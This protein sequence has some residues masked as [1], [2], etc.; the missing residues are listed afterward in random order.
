MG[1]RI[2]IDPLTRLEGQGKISIFL[3]D[4]GE[5]ERAYFQS[6]DLRGFEKFCEGRAAEELPVLTQ[7]ICGV[8]PTAHH[9]A[10]S[11]ALDDL[12]Q[13][14]PPP[15]ARKIR[16]LI[17]N[18]FI[19]EDHLL[20]FYFLGGCDLLLGEET[21]VAER[22]FL[23]VMKRVG[24]SLG[25]KVIQVR[26]EVR[27][28][29]T[30]LSGGPLYPVVGLPGGVSKSLDQ[31]DRAE[32]IRVAP[33]AL[34]LARESLTLFHQTLENKKIWAK[35]LDPIFIQSTYYLGLVDQDQRVN[36]YDGRLRVVDPGGEELACFQPGDYSRHLGERTE[37]WTY[38]RIPYLK[39]IGWKGWFEGKANGIYRAGPLGRLNASRGMATP[40][41]QAEYARMISRFGA[42]PV[43]HTLAYHWARLI[44]TLYAAERMQELA[45]DPEL[46]NPEVR[47]IP[48]A[49]PR[50]G[51]GVCEASRGTLIH[52]YRTDERG[53]V[54]EM[55]LLVATQ[56]SM[57]ALCLA[58]EKAAKGL[59]HK[60]RASEDLLNQIEM[61][62]RA[63][64]PCLACATHCLPGQSPLAVTFYT[65]PSPPGRAPAKH[66]NPPQP[67][68]S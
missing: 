38:S 34:D 10:S 3:D 1:K 33:L 31:E 15:A 55:K 43:H 59:I 6:T 67:P 21:P 4:Q 23:G 27:G 7:K 41:A 49:V 36:F 12:F 50:E 63:Y 61:V 60:G 13:V 58:I 29:Q 9:L 17:L 5:V 30:R 51:I 53:V 39:A 47:R 52:H 56:N 22:N 48:S 19:F 57:A 26:K 2:D 45:A 28:L 35:F 18:A 46:T 14:A 66:E 42:R 44:E 62:Y 24:R 68:F 65:I 32:A 11:K 16:E 20:H 25:E 37:P 8:C 40:E 64:D 54:Q